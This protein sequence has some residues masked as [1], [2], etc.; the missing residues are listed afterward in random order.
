[1]I[2]LLKM[3]IIFGQEI[4][5]QNNSYRSRTLRK[6]FR[7]HGNKWIQEKDAVLKI[8][9]K[10]LEL[11]ENKDAPLAIYLAALNWFG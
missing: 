9:I 10:I 7:C 6:R 11:N 5:N 2:L 4:S 3:C 1:M 8:A